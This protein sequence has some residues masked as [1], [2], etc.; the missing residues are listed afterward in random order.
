MGGSGM[1]GSGMG[2][3]G[4]GGSGNASSSSSGM[5]DPCMAGCAANTWDVDGNPLTGTCGCEYKCTQVSADADPIDENYTDENCD[6][7]DGIAEQCIYVSSGQ[8]SDANAGTR[9]DP[10][11]TIAAAISKAQMV[12]VP[13]V[14]L[15]GEIYNE[16]V[17]VVSG[18]SIYGGFDVNDADFRFRRTAA[19][20]T[21]VNAAGTV[22]DAPQIDQ[23][24][25][26]EGITIQATTPAGAAQSTYGVH[27]GGGV[28]TLYV[29]F[30]TMMIAAGTNGDKG[31]DGTPPAQSSAPNGGNGTK[32]GQK[33]NNSGIG[34]AAPVCDAPGGKGGDG[35][36]DAAAGQNGAAGNGG[37]PGGN[38]AGANSCT[39]AIG[40]PGPSGGAGQ[41]GTDS[42]Q[43]N[44]GQGGN[45][46]GTVNASFYNPS[47]GS[48]GTNA[49]NGK[50]G[51]GGGGGG[52]GKGDGLCFGDWDKGGGGGA[53]GCG[54][55]G[56]LGGKGGQG[57]GGSFGV[58]AAAGKII[59]SKNDITTSTGG[60]GGI[61]GNG[62]SGQL[63]GVGG[64]GG[65][66]NDD[67]GPG[68]PGGKGGKGA[69]GGPGGGGGGG[70]SACLARSGAVTFTFAM[71]SCSTGTPGFGANG[72][73]NPEGGI[74]GKG[75][76]GTAGPNVQ[77][78]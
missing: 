74:G 77:L 38:G 20:T 39:P 55:K 14:C 34:A 71:N 64:T 15:S 49:P 43:G 75:L 30:D 48:D 61:G 26:I 72:G 5:V 29:R 9:Q 68:G 58:F 2:G 45:T 35:G 70:P 37:T 54:G 31:A 7:S 51:G 50:A 17:K 27:L 63:G 47:S 19:V 32:G 10:M 42:T 16:A 18:I 44:P 41:S 13:S 73:T 25:H 67:S 36:A 69:A 66:N 33:D 60:A 6:G 21:T 78:N 62:A 46:L 59:V 56:G 12:G 8:G 3:S 28:G 65:G 11:Q 1:G 40:S 52:G 57:G 24:T 4:M 22:F 53:G 23:D 76:N